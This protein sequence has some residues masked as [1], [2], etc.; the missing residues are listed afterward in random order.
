MSSLSLK[1]ASHSLRKELKIFLVQVQQPIYKMRTKNPTAYVGGGDRN[2]LKSQIY[3]PKNDVTSEVENECTRRILEK[4]RK[5]TALK[6]LGI[7][8]AEYDSRSILTNE[9]ISSLSITDVYYE[10]S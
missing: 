7:T 3:S 2:F 4:E 10:H 8:N 6:D 5:L 9:I 1:F